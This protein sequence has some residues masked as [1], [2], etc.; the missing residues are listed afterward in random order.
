[1]TDCEVRFPDYTFSGS[2]NVTGSTGVYVQQHDARLKNIQLTGS[3]QDGEIGVRVASGRNRVYIEVDTSGNGAEDPMTSNGV[4]GTNDRVVKFDDNTTTGIVYVVHES[5]EEPVQIPAD[6]GSGLKIYTR[7]N[8]ATTWTELEE[9]E[10][11][12]Q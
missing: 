4:D 3:P 1:M 9:G 5:S 12:P 8:T 7:L 10:A 2:T 6:W 11:Y